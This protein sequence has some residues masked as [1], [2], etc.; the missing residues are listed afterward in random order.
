M[1]TEAWTQLRPHVQQSRAWRTQE[2]FVA[3]AAGRGSG[4]TELAR[5]RLVRYL[6]IKK[7]WSNPMYFYAGPTY[8]QAKRVAWKAIKALIPKEWIESISETELAIKTVFGSELW[9]VGMDKPHRIE[10]NQWD[11]VVID[12]SSDIKPG[13]FALSVRPALSHREAWCW[14]IGVPKRNGVGALEFRECFDEASGWES[15]NWP[16]SD[17]LPPGEI[18]DAKEM[19]DSKDFAEQYEA[20]W[21][22]SGGSAFHDF[23]PDKHIRPVGYD[24]TR[25]IIVGS[26]FNVNPMAWILAHKTNDGL[27][28]FDEIWLR[29]SHTR[30]TLDI[31]HS[32]YS[33]HESSWLFM[34]DASGQ[35]RKTSATKSDY[36]IIKSD[37]RF[38]SDIFYPK[39]NPA[40]KDRLA[41]C[42][43]LLHHDK[44]HID[45]SCSNLIRDLEF[46]GLDGTGNPDDSGD[47]GHISDAFGYVAHGLYPI[48]LTT[49]GNIS[50]SVV[51]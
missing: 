30:A 46:R 27:E 39:A 47:Q 43:A 19:L 34:G 24:K 32:R 22:K 6:P 50:L 33:D 37:S 15:Y 10:G 42:N 35:A 11:G 5:R 45:G 44:I 36:I 21:V 7:P 20:S 1:I 12:E 23:E 8:G 9:V 18:Q 25:Q 4:K 41:S 14:R 48:R 40:V 3:I 2:R 49:Q 31:L 29:D 13:T 28:I 16:S 26:D 38:A 51:S 17:I